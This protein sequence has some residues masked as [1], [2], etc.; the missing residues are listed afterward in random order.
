MRGGKKP[1]AQESSEDKGAEDVME[2]P[3]VGSPRSLRPGTVRGHS[4]DKDIKDMSDSVQGPRGGK[5]PGKKGAEEDDDEPDTP[6]AA[7]PLR[8]SSVRGHSV[9]EDESPAVSSLRPTTLRGHSC[10]KDLEEMNNSIRGGKKPD[11]RSLRDTAPTSPKASYKALRDAAPTTPKATSTKKFTSSES[12]EAA[13]KASYAHAPTTPKTPSRSYNTPKT[14]TRAAPK[15]PTRPAVAPSTPKTP[16]SRSRGE[17]TA[18]P[19]PCYTRVDEHGV[20][21]KEYTWE[22]PA[23]ATSSALRA[24]PKGEKLKQGSDLSRPIGGIKQ[25]D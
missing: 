6:K 20:E 19:T 15:T 9:I 14:P 5:R 7:N 13:A 12:P 18:P 8:P 11:Y 21:H 2:T 22:K 3:K 23:W 10:D 1:S 25:V 4:F 16:G 24:T 17:D